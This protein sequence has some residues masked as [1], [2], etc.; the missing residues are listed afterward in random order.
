[1]KNDQR[2]KV[3]DTISIYDPK[4]KAMLGRLTVRHSMTKGRYYEMERFKESDES[5]VFIGNS[6]TKEN[7]CRYFMRYKK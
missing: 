6:Y 4:S 3:G 5:F 2:E 1:M 7:A